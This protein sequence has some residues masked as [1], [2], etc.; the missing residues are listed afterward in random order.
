MFSSKKKNKPLRSPSANPFPDPRPMPY[1]FSV[2]VGSKKKV[3]RKRNPVFFPNPNR[4]HF[5]TYYTLDPPVLN[6]SD[7]FQFLFLFSSAVYLIMNPPSPPPFP[8]PCS[9]RR[10]QMKKIH[11]PVL[12]H[13]LYTYK[14][15]EMF[16]GYTFPITAPHRTF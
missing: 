13:R 14:C 15:V 9:L 10:Q 1:F 16:V 11:S 2:V 5:V 12:L 8:L 7:S 6:M 3:I 4:L